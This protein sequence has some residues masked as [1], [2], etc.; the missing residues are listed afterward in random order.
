L[1]N[2]NCEKAGGGMFTK[3]IEKIK[4]LTEKLKTKAT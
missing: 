1:R 4:E 2:A 3:E